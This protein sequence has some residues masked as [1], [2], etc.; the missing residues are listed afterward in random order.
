MTEPER[1]QGRV[2]VLRRISRIVFIAELAIG[3][4]ALLAILAF[5]FL[6]ALQRYLPIEGFPWTGELARFS[7]VWLTFSAAGLLVTS[8]G[9]IALEVVDVAR[10]QVLVRVVQVFAMLVV[11]ATGV[12]LTLEAWALVETQ[13]IIKS[14]VLRLPMSYVYIPVLIGAASTAIRAT[15]AAIDV[16]VNGPVITTTESD[17]QEATA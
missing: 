3:S 15:I 11:A 13:S 2:P 17:E 6:Q 1:P 8:R 7:L 10:N 14:P 5:V 4:I 16:A 9:H 12:G